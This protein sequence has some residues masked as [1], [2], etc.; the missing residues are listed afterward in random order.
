[1]FQHDNSINPLNLGS[2]GRDFKPAKA[3]KFKTLLM[4]GFEGVV[5]YAVVLLL[6][7]ELNLSS[8]IANE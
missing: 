2:T 1:M 6:S 3:R 4:N 7:R 5:D 8:L